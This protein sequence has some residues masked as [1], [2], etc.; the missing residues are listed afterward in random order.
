M[1]RAGALVYAVFLSI[2]LAIVSGFFIL[3]AYYQ[4]QYFDNAILRESLVSDVNSAYNVLLENW[5]VIK[6]KDAAEI[7]LYSDDEHIVIVQK[8]AWGFYENI[9]C[10]SIRNNIEYSKKAMVG[11]NVFTGEG[12]AL[13]LC[14]YNNYLSLCGNTILK[15]ICWLPKKGVKPAF[16]EGKS[17]SGSKYVEG[18]IKQ[19]ESTLPEIN[20]N[21]IL[22][23]K[24]YLEGKSKVQDSLI[25]YESV[26]KDT[27]I[28]SFNN[29]TLCL[30]SDNVLTLEDKTIIGNIIVK[31]AKGIVIEPSTNIRDIVLY[32][33][34][35]EVKEGFKGSFQSINSDSILIKEDCELMFPSVLALIISD[36]IDVIKYINIDE[37]SIV[38]GAVILYNEKLLQNNKSILRIEKDAVV[39]GQVYCN[40]FT[41]HKGR[42]FGSLYTSKLLLETKSAIYESHL[43]DSEVNFKDLSTYYSGSSLFENYTKKEVIK[44]LH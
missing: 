35:L 31:S 33:P 7:D 22:Y 15:G 2:I 43:L 28:N 25:W 44:W 20:K 12:V 41:D 36:E 17:F 19:S 24:D 10:K 14:D 6:D 34:Y 37:N 40:S 9:I 11:D 29:K 4:N 39:N 23:H 16:I 26:E 13:Y 18:T 5:S 38:S 42:I 3:R 21:L 1:I 27:I 32:A 30:Y 8:K